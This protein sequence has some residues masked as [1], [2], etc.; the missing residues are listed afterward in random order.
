MNVIGMLKPKYS[1]TYL[2]A[3]DSLR[4]GLSI[5]RE[6]R[7]TAVPVISNKGEYIGTVT[8][9]DFL[10]RILD[11]GEAVLDELKVKDIVK[12]GWNSAA[13]DSIEDEEL[14]Q[15]TLQ[16]NFVPMV[17]DRNCYMGIIT[18]RDFIQNILQKKVDTRYIINSNEISFA[19]E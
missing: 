7:Y 18:R 9:G 5:L 2:E 15:M 11:R 10:W 6:S 16:Q 17:D 8:E 1:T 3:E 14:I 13:V 19:Q 4:E 12:E